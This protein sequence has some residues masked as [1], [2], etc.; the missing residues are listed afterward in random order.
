[1]V[2]TAK[3]DDETLTGASTVE[4]YGCFSSLRTKRWKRKHYAV[5]LHMAIM[6]I[7]LTLRPE[8]YFNP[9]FLHHLE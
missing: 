3:P 6:M 8:A 5:P 9:P 1:M 4:G 2:V 7:Y